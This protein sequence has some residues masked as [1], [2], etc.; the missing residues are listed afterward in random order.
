[1]GDQIKVSAVSQASN[2]VT[3][4]WD[5]RGDIRSD[6]VTIFVYGTNP[7]G[8]QT[9]AGPK[10]VQLKGHY[11]DFALN[12]LDGEGH[13]LIGL[14]AHFNGDHVM[15]RWLSSDGTYMDKPCSR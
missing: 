13:P 11:I 10:P 2:R 4:I 7:D 8:S 6:G 12:Q 15:S 3:I 9:V 1:V 14:F 5:S